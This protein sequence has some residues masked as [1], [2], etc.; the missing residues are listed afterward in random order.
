MCVFSV[1][2]PRGTRA[3]STGSGATFPVDHIRHTDIRFIRLLPPGPVYLTYMY[4]PKGRPLNA[5]IDDFQDFGGVAVEPQWQLQSRDVRVSCKLLHLI[6]HSSGPL[7]ISV[8]WQW[9]VFS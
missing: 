4:A 7:P 5:G 1:L 9:S 6:A 3:T 2:T 8:E